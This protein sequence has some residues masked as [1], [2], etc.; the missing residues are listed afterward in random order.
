MQNFSA[1][2][3]AGYCLST[4]SMWASL[5]GKYLV[6]FG[7]S[8]ATWDWTTPGVYSIYNGQIGCLI[9]TRLKEHQWHIHSEHLDKSAMMEQSINLGHSI[10]LHQSTLLTKPRYKYHIIKEATEIEF[11]F[12]MNTE[13]G[14]CLSK[15]W[16]PLVCSLRD[17]MK[18]P[19]HNS[20]AGFFSEPHTSMCTALIT[21]GTNCGLS[22]LTILHSDVSAY[23]CYLIPHCMPATH[24]LDIS[25]L[26]VSALF[27]TPLY[28]YPPPPLFLIPEKLSLFT[29]SPNSYYCLLSVCSVV[30]RPKQWVIQWELRSTLSLPCCFLRDLKFQLTECSS[31]HLTTCSSETYCYMLESRD[32]SMETPKTVA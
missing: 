11:C 6:P 27:N 23:L 15:S 18:P 4:S 10:Q 5:P 13:D 17:W 24:S 19:T 3:F 32:T 16:K 9:D 12:N 28:F 31:W 26:Y 30:V 21:A 25:S 22:A 29:V 7:Q 1:T 20:R 8:R 14:F 2:P